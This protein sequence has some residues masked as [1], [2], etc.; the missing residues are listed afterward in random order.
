M[1]NERQLSSLKTFPIPSHIV[2]QLTAERQQLENGGNPQKQKKIKF[3]NPN[4]GNYSNNLEYASKI[5]KEE[6]VPTIY[7][8][9]LKGKKVVVCGS[10]P[11]LGNNEVLDNIRSLKEQGH[12]IVACKH[13]I[14]SLYDRG[15]AIDWAV[16]MDPGAHIARPDKKI[17]KAPGAKHIAASTSDPILFRYLRS[18]LPYKEWLETLTEEEQKSV[19]TTDFEAWKKGEFVFADVPEQLPA[20][21][22]IFHSA[23]GLED[24]YNLYKQKFDHGECMGGGYNVVN[25]AVAAMLFMGVSKITLAGTDCGWRQ[26]ESFYVDGVPHVDGVDMCDNGMID[27]K[28]WMTRPDMLA[29]GISIAKLAKKLPGVFD[30][31]G[32]TLPSKLAKKDD[33]FLKRCGDFVDQN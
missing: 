33:E 2:I 29:S 11:S 30:F 16:T 27:G 21:V 4:V 25:R 19:L 12:L 24:E 6:G 18:N 3:V 28:P 8:N 14:K 22:F 20:E 15:I 13:A 32:D 23:T 31:L 17:Y 1:F 5:H 9:Q 26:D 10:G 7:H